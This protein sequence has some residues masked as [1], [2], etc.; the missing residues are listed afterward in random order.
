MDEKGK[1]INQTDK[2]IL[3]IEIPESLTLPEANDAEKTEQTN[4]AMQDTF[5]ETKENPEK[6]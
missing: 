5:A 3:D 4:K 6:V 2:D 1:K